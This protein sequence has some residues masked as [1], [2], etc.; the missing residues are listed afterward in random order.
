MPPTHREKSRPVVLMVED[1]D[2]FSSE[3]G[4]FLLSEGCEI[5]RVRDGGEA[6]RRIQR[7]PVPRLLLLDLLLPTV[8]G[9]HFYAELRKNPE[10]PHIPIVVLTGAGRME[11]TGLVGIVDFLRKPR[12][13]EALGDF[14]LRLRQHLETFVFDEGAPKLEAL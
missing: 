5:E 11:S 2:N 12:T 1:D 10:L 14:Q 7:V 4:S 13:A 9:W 3:L 6:L 8:D